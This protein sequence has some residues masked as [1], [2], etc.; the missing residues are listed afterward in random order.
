MGTITAMAPI[1]VGI[2]QETGLGAPLCLGAVV[3]GAMFGDNLSM[4]SD[5][6]IAAVR[7]QGCEMKDKFKENFLIVLPAAIITAAIFFFVA[8]AQSGSLVLD[9]SAYEYEI[10][11][12]I[13]YLVVLVGALIGVNVFIILIAGTILSAIVGVATGGFCLWGAVPENGRRGLPVCMIL[14]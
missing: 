5:T 1:G 10:I 7:T 6:T 12:V 2:A 13:P 3:C 14:R 11:K 8:R 4:I 9:K